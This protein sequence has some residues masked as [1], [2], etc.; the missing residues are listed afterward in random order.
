MLD[1][2]LKIKGVNHGQ[3]IAFTGEDYQSAERARGATLATLMAY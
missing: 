1:Y 2:G 3:E